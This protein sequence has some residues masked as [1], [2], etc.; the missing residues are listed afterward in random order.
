MCFLR[1]PFWLVGKGNQTERRERLPFFGWSSSSRPLQANRL[2]RILLRIVSDSRCRSW[3]WSYITLNDIDSLG[4]TESGPKTNSFS[5]IMRS[6]LYSTTQASLSLPKRNDLRT[7][8]HR[9]PKNN[10]VPQE[11]PGFVKPCEYH[12][13]WS[14][15]AKA[16]SP[17]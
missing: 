7:L 4:I 2:P 16:Q 10:P 6:N 5:N 15:R 9:H 3:P 13:H 1:H 11:T 8:C 14:P 17:L 12:G